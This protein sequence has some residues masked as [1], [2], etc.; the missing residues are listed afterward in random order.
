MKINGH[1]IKPMADLRG[2]NLRGAKHDEKTKWP[3]FQIPQE[4]SLTVYKKVSNGVAKLQIPVKAKR[5][6]S[7]VGRKCRAEFAKV[8][9]VPKGAVSNYDKTTRYIAGEIVRP[10]SYD[11]N[12]LVECAPGIH[13][14]LTREEAEQY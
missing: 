5:T 13:F 12:F 6:A 2:A 4:G 9:S 14:F 7:V 1:E 3:P 10:D 8:I 11:D